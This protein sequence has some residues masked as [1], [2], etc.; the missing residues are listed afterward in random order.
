MLN[1]GLA[2][3]YPFGLK[4]SLHRLLTYKETWMP[5]NGQI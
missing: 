4:E 5:L 2:V 1:T 3:G